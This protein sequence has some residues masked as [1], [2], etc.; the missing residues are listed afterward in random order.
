MS[1]SNE[2]VIAAAPPP[3]GVTPNFE[4][5]ES[6]SHQ[7][8][9]VSVVFP[10]VSF[11]FLIPRLYSASVIRRRWHR[12]D[13]LI[14]VA[15]AFGLAN[16]VLCIIQSTMGMG[17]H[18]WEI[19][20]ETFKQTIKVTT[21]LPSTAAKTNSDPKQLLTLGGAFTYNIT[22]MFIKLSI[23]SFY[24]RFSVDKS[25]RIAVYIVMFISSGY[26]IPNA[27]IFLYM[28][29]PI[30]SVWDW[31]VPGTCINQQAIFDACNILNMVTDYMILLLPFWMLR[32]LRIP[33][34]KK[35]GIGFVLAAGGFVCG[36]STMRMI[37]AMTGAN[38]PDITWHYPV[39]LIWCLVE[40]YVGIICA[41]LPGLK[42][43]TNYFYPSLFL[44][45]PNVDRRIAAS[46]SLASRPRR[47]GSGTAGSG[48]ERR[49]DT[50]DILPGDAKDVG[51][52]KAWWRLVGAGLASSGSSRGGTTAASRIT[53]TGDSKVRSEETPCFSLDVDVEAG[54]RPDPGKA[55]GVVVATGAPS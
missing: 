1:S 27:L 48:N 9:V 37:T 39:N 6:S 32:P 45:S 53:K 10:L 12:D 34:S 36:V 50:D 26:S 5:P 47:N 46:S 52:R 29:R 8:I 7:L 2:T 42:D 40:E 41:C 33:L 13:Y 11:F 24:L 44:F 4:K 15:A 54:R 16:A 30:R 18:I 55:P 3:P 19:D 23:L 35:L 43:F 51:G 38:N 21:P 49:N 25:F 17:K 20:Y 14:C 22:T 31:T 28:C